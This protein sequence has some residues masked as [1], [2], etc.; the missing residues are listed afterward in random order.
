MSDIEGLARKLADPP[1]IG[2]TPEEIQNFSWMTVQEFT[3]RQAAYMQLVVK[4]CKL[5]FT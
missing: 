3:K 2:P 1:K 5:N 4:P